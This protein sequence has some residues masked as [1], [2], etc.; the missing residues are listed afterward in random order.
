MYELIIHFNILR[1]NIYMPVYVSTDM[2][3]KGRGG[4]GVSSEGPIII[5]TMGLG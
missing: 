5:M 4:G 2:E 3:K 1:A